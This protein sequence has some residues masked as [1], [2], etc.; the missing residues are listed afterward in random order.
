MKKFLNCHTD[1]FPT[2]GVPAI[3]LVFTIFL[4][5][6]SVPKMVDER[7]EKLNEEFTGI[8]AYA[9]YE[10][11][12][13]SWSEALKK[14][15]ENNHEMIR[16][17]NE[18]ESARHN[19]KRVWLNLVPLVN[20]GYYYNR[21]ILGDDDDSYDGSSYNLN[22]IFNIPALTRLPVDYYVAELAFF[23]AEKNLELKT[24]ELIS[25]LYKTT[26]EARLSEEIFENSKK[27]A[28]RERQNL[29]EEKREDELRVQ[30]LALAQLLGDETKQFKIVG[31]IPAFPREQYLE[32]SK[33]I[34]LLVATLMATEL[35]ASRLG[36]IGIKMNYCPTVTVN[37]YSPSLFNYS[38]GNESGFYSRE[39]DLRMQLDFYVQLDTQL[40]TYFSL[41]EAEANHELLEKT[42]HFQMVERREKIALVLKS[43]GE[44]ERWKAAA[45]R[46]ERFLQQQVASSPEFYLEYR[47]KCMDLRN[48]IFNKERENIEREAALILEYGLS[49]ND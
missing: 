45:L 37:F 49:G 34:D 18:I 43:Q 11:C 21:A 19:C 27:T 40:S 28:P 16:A 32:R 33:K 14:M 30:W 22:I 41:E 44:F 48:Q 2:N 15:L 38:G 42:L 9:T 8:P 10:I 1:L 24:R 23:R 12:E 20:L 35:E 31:E 46:Y 5:A 39:R 7:V 47:K 36:K 25:K 6:C 26:R 4:G 29:L 13:I 3:L 17:R